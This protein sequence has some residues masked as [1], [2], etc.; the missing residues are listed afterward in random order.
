VV[1]FGG[2]LLST[3]SL[4]LPALAPG[5]GLS[6]HIETQSS[7]QYLYEFVSGD[8][9]TYVHNWRYAAELPYDRPTDLDDAVDFSGKADF[10]R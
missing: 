1:K 3:G 4:L 5:G 9:G 2:K 10:F 6:A 7:T 8:P